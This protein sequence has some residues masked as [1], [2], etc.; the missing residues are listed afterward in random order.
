MNRNLGVDL[1]ESE[2]AVQENLDLASKAMEHG[3]F[4]K[5]SAY[6]AI[7]AVHQARV[8]SIRT[9]LWRMPR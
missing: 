6:A 2:G 5:A 1:L 9:S 4:E 8:E 7:A 3:K